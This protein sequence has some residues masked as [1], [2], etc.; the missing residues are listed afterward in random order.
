MGFTGDG[1]AL[2]PALSACEESRLSLDLRTDKPEGLVF[3]VGPTRARP[4][5]GVTGEFFNFFI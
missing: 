5:F 3:Y 2:Y 4:P 1:W